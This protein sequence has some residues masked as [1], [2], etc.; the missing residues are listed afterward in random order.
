MSRRKYCAT[1]R[2]L[3]YRRV[4]AALCASRSTIGQVL[5]GPRRRSLSASFIF[6]IYVP[7]R[8]LSASSNAASIEYT[9]RTRREARL[10]FFFFPPPSDVGPRD[11]RRDRETKRRCKIRINIDL[12]RGSPT[13]VLYAAGKLRLLHTSR[14]TVGDKNVG[15]LMRT[16][17]AV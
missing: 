2:G 10:F 1:I 13:I 16:L 15:T 9:Q 4:S 12:L 8:N 14:V 17:Y 5:V 3:F 7:S 11:H 6:K